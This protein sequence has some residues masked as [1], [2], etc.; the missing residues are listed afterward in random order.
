MKH[1]RTGISNVVALILIVTV[2]LVISI[3][4]AYYLISAVT[5]IYEKS[6]ETLVIRGDSYITKS[7]GTY[8][9]RIHFYSNI[10]PKL[11][12]YAVKI[13]PKYVKLNTSSNVRIMSY[14]GGKAELTDKGLVLEPGTD[15]WIEVQVQG[16]LSIGNFIEVKAFTEAGYVYRGVLV[17]K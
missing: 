15:A 11:M 10:R 5:P 7:N 3:A 17:F 9:A 2:A 12:I 13:G 8:I 6:S 14:S 1:T 16:D 4:V